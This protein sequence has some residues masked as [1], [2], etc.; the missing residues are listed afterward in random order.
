LLID[1]HLVTDTPRSPTLAF[2]ACFRT[3]VSSPSEIVAVVPPVSETESEVG[4]R[5]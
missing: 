3:R 2:A 5:P 1:E 4:R